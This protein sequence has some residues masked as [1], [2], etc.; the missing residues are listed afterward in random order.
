MN[1]KN[2]SIIY[3]VVAILIILLGLLIFSNSTVIKSVDNY[4]DDNYKTTDFNKEGISSALRLIDDI[5]KYNIFFTGEFHRI[6]GNEAVNLEMLKY[7]NK[8]EDVNYLICEM[9]YSIICKLNKYIQN[10]DEK[11]LKDTVNIVRQ[12]S[13]QRSAQYVGDDYYK[14]WQG[15]YEFN[16]GL[17]KDKKIQAYGIDMDFIGDY[18][19]S[20][21]ANLIP[22]N[23]PPTEIASKVNKFKGI[24]SG[25]ISD[26]K[27]AITILK[28]LSDDYNTNTQVYKSFFGDNFND[29]KNNL[30]S[31]INTGKYAET[32]D[33]NRDELIYDNFMRIYNQNQKGK[34]YGQFGAAHIFR[35][36]I[37]SNGKTFYTLAKM[38][39]KNDGF[40]VL[41]IPIVPSDRMKLI[42]QGEKLAKGRF[43][44]FKLNGKGSPY[45]QQNENIFTSNG[46][47]IVNGT[48][49][50]N[51]QYVVYLKSK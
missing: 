36:D 17:P 21:M 39:E 4:L 24:I 37:I 31:M 33:S 16:K 18:T 10:G 20:E 51:Y 40:K 22:H 32:Q 29:F 45:K 49:V 48:T 3:I 14:F 6:S 50:D 15:L 47:G 27:E 25:E 23:E 44:I 19:L 42:T 41:S 7:L 34:Y 13:D 11:L 28:D 2:K 8:V 26:E 38:I 35:E 1:T 30:S 43:S 5:D 9:Q 46:L 12:R